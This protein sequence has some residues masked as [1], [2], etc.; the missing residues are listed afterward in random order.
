M[1]HDGVAIILKRAH[2]CATG[3][4][5]LCSYWHDGRLAASAAASDLALV[6]A[7]RC[8]LPGLTL[9]RAQSELLRAADSPTGPTEARPELRH[10]AMLISAARK[11]LTTHED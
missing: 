11:A 10:V 9:Q 5:L 8:P 2:D 3:A 7:G 6:I 4:L 1:N